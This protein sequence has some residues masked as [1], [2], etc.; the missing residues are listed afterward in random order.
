MIGARE[1][2]KFCVTLTFWTDSA[3]CRVPLLYTSGG[4]ALPHTET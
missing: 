1:A 2:E 4:R 3:I